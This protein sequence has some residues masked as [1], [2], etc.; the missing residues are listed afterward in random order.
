MKERLLYKLIIIII[1]QITARLQRL[2]LK[3]L[4][5]Q[6]ELQHL[7]ASKMLIADQL[8]TDCLKFDGSSKLLNET[9][10]SVKV[11]LSVH[12]GIFFYKE[13]IVIPK[14]LREE[15]KKIF[16]HYI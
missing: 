2:K 15:M 5:Y 6:I 13:R 12:E 4:K 7:P 1:S 14:S 16:M 8:S 10:Y 3:L 11:P 9:V